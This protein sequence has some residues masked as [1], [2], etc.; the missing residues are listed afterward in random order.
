MFIIFMG[1]QTLNL[2]YKCHYWLYSFYWWYYLGY[3]ACHERSLKTCLI[4]WRHKR[5]TL[6]NSHALNIKIRNS[7]IIFILH[8]Q[9]LLFVFNRR[10]WQMK[11]GK[12]SREKAKQLFTL[13]KTF[14]DEI[15]KSKIFLTLLIK[16]LLKLLLH[17]ALC[18][19]FKCKSRR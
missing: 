12:N 14:I 7:A 15:I 8:R 2:K 18:Q 1:L 6:I 5:Y 4:L 9:Q 16:V 3:I 13:W 11:Q 17:M 10:P 19:K